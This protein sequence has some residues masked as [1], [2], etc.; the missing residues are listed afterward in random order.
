MIETI[1][2]P[3]RV[4]SSWA[5]TIPAQDAKREGVTKA[6]ELRVTFEVVKKKQPKLIDEYQDFVQQYGATL[7]NLAD[8]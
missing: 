7:K 3:I 6:T 1:R 8:K 4:G 5:I 2:R